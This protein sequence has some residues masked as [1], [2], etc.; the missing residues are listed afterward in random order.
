MNPDL[1]LALALA[2]EAD[3]ITM[4]HFQS[5][6]LS[7]RTKSD[8][9]PV[10]EADEATE[11]MLRERLAHE[12]PHDGVI[13]E[14]FGST[15]SGARRWVLD[16]ID[17]TKNYIRGVPVWATLIALEENGVMNV[18]VISAPAITRRWWAAR[19]EGAFARGGD[20]SEHARRLQASRV[21][22]IGEAFLS[23]DSVN[24]F[25][26]SDRFLG[27]VRQ[28]G[29]TRAFGDFWSHMLVAEGAIDIAIE[30]KIALWDVAPIQVIVEEAGGRFSDVRGNATPDGGSVLTTNGILHDAVLELLR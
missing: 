27:L 14:E 3:A 29:R 10:S 21:A 20:A 28:C 16:P 30:P 11:K 2:D 12:R 1:Q 4:R 18:G 25:N 19:G 23:Y 24:D 7:V 15:G 9:T 5:A 13:G 17:G 6:T 22:S 26:P 8:R